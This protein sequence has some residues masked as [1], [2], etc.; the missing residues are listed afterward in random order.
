L[1]TSFAAMKLG[2]AR[3]GTGQSS[4]TSQATT[5]RRSNVRRRSAVSS[6]QDNPPGSGVPTA[7]IV[8]GSSPSR[9]IVM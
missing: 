4:T 7:G 5:F 6:R 2:D 1:Y 9:S 3:P 8:A